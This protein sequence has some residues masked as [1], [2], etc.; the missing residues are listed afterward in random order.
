M[1]D[2]EGINLELIYVADPMCSWCWGFAP[3][4]EKID[5]S[6]AI[7]LRTIVGGLRPGDRAEPIDRIRPML[8]HHW[9]QVAAASG[10]PFDL[11][12]LDRTDW[13]Y[14]TLVPDTAVVTMRSMA[15]DVTLRFLTTLQRAFYSERIDITDPDT[16]ANLI[17]DFPVD[18]D[19][20]V[21]A[22]R[23]P[24]MLAA[25]ERDF[26]EAQWLGVT[27][28]PTLLLRDGAT[29]VPLS[30]GYA[31]FERVAERINAFVE[32]NHPDTA[33]GLVCDIDG[34]TC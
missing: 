1:T 31:P 25:T 9:G 10:Q 24:E 32:K 11:E 12:G 8:A 6:F 13:M 26:Q 29:T 2:D 4:V 5:D 20:F 7:P 14:D 18:P 17:S 21:E 30:L 27:G 34:D 22:I 23:S 3:V 28:F 19:A 15:P 16:H 33:V